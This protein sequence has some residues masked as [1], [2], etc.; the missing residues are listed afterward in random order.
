MDSSPCLS[1]V[2][3]VF[4][5]QRGSK[6]PRKVPLVVVM[7]SYAERLGVLLALYEIMCLAA[8]LRE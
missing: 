3:G 5:S 6:E 4:I 8:G 7:G 1:C 2:A